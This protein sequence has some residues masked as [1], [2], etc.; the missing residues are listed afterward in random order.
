MPD[1]K[2]DFPAAYSKRP[3]RRGVGPSQAWED[4]TALV[5]RKMESERAASDDKTS[6][7]KALRLAREAS[8]R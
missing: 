5:K 1:A 7:L 6:R 4:R 2:P 3:A 8:G